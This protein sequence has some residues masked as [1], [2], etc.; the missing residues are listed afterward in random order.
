M[1]QPRLRGVLLSIGIGEQIWN[2]LNEICL[3]DGR[4][5]SFERSKNKILLTWKVQLQNHFPMPCL[6]CVQIMDAMFRLTYR[7]RSDVTI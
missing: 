2:I 6:E 4:L 5:I 1:Q 7:E 3:S